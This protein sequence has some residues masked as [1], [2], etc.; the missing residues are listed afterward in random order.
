MPS[1]IYKFVRY[2]AL[3]IVVSF[4]SASFVFADEI[5][6]SK[7]WHNFRG[8]DR[9]GATT[10][11]T[12][13]TE[14]SS[15]KNVAWKVELPGS[16][17]SSPIVWGDQ[18]FI[19][20][21]VRVGENTASTPRL[22]RRELF[23]KFDENGDG[24]LSD[25]E[26]DRAVAFQREQT[27]KSLTKHQ[28]KVMCFDKN[29]GKMIWEDVANERTPNE[30]HH[31]DHGYASA[32]PITDG[33]H[34]FFSFGT[35]GVFCY[36]LDGKQIWKRTDLGEMQT[37]GSFGEGS[38]L[39]MNEDTLVLPWDHE[40]QSRTEALDKKTGKTKWKVMR[41]EPSTWSTPRIVTIGD[42]SQVVQSGEN[43]TRG[44]DLET[45][46]EIWRSSGLSTRPVATPVIQGNIGIFASSRRGATMDAYRLDKTGDISSEPVWQIR[47]Q[48]P[49]CPSLLLSENRLYYIGSNNGVLSCA[50]SEDGSEFFGA[51]RMPGIS[52]V[53]SSPVAG[54]GYVFV[55]GRGG[56]TLVIKDSEDFEVVANND[57]GEP[58][59]A[60]IA[61]VGDQ[62]FIRGKTHLFCIQSDKNE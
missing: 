5:D 40:G 37:R 10:T 43:Y 15:T 21:A 12:P 9:N 22:N 55:T 16:G 24:Q 44:Y 18:I 51:Q 45:G 14:W 59:D 47:E 50:D 57:I 42:K 8:P 1:R 6:F 32:S 20:A 38:S 58:V 33:K 30:G 13:P 27:K 23:R 39:A 41:D 2:I 48:T 56:K 17:T 3:A 29:T 35:N 28:F 49:D 34:V 54:G 25:D 53:Y 11:A 31:R 60:T 62:L 19:T 61:M 46:K 26:R 36:T 7:N 52:G 4:L